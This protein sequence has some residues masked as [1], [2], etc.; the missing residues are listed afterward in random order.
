MTYSGLTD[1]LRAAGLMLALLWTITLP[2][3]AQITIADDDTELPD[4][5]D[6]YAAVEAM[7]AGDYDTA[8]AEFRRSAEEGLHLAQYNL[9]V[10]YYTGQGVQQSYDT[11]FYW[12][13]QA[14]DQGHLN[15]MFNLATM[16]YNGQ[17]VNSALMQL[18]PLSLISRRQNLQE[19]ANWYQ[20]AA[21]YEHAGAQYNLATMYEAGEGVEQDLVRAYVWARLARDN[22]A[23][24]AAALV[25]RIQSAMTPAQRDQAQRDYA[26]WVL[27]FRG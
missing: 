16:Y 20:E 1:K 7:E 11:A 10:M 9:G 6:Y 8:L 5:T 22:E 19:A 13:S 24:G 23:N 15:S 27:S 12:M 2:A 4:Y 14:A 3:Q 17:G 26:Q 25:N 18:W 21:E